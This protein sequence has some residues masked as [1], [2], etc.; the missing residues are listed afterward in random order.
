MGVGSNEQWVKIGMSIHS[1]LPTAGLALWSAWSAKDPE[2]AEEW[3]K[4]NPCEGRWKSFKAGGIG[5][6]TLIWMADQVDPKR[7]RFSESSKSIVEKAEEAAR[8]PNVPYLELIRRGMAAYENE[9]V[10]F[11]QYQLHNLAVEAKYKDQSALENVLLAYIKQQ[12]RSSGFTM[13]KRTAATRDFLIPGLLPS[14]YMV[15]FY[16]EA[17]CGKSATALTLLKHVVDGIPFQLKNQLVPVE[18]GPVIYFNGDMS[19]TDFYEEYDLHEIKNHH[20]FHFEPD[21]DMQRRIQFQKKMSEV[22]PRMV[23]IDSLSSCS[24]SK[25]GDE[26]KAEFAQPLYWMTQSNGELWPDCTIIVLHHAA[27]A[28]GARGST[29]IAAAVSEVW[30]ISHP[31]KDSGLSVDQRV[32]TIGKS[33]INRQGETLIQTQNDDLTVS[34]VEASKPEELQ[35]RSGTVGERI[36]NRLQTN[37]GWMSRQEMCSDPLINGSVA[38]IRK[39]LQRLENRGVVMVIERPSSHGSATKLYKAVSTTL[40]T[41][42]WGESIKVSHLEENPC[43]DRD[44]KG[45]TTPG[46]DICP[47]SPGTSALKGDN[48]AEK[49]ECPTSKPSVD[50]GSASSGTSS[51][52][53]RAREKSGER[54]MEELQRMRDQASKLW[55]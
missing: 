29:A 28:G 22:K 3:V 36:M 52:Y 35:T 50:A 1:V 47:T 46:A 33:R 48:S 2:F 53:S 19:T 9:D 15:L 13:D 18:Q 40:S 10:A 23:V 27:K 4:G 34:L 44:V 8:E 5:L 16:G 38:A 49:E 6:G 20:L 55:D 42:A 25:A 21:F 37:Q 24:G 45:D 30:N 32:I 14:N 12:N 26:N 41:R 51:L 39:T 7:A 31:K 54:S 43:N 11:M 17:G